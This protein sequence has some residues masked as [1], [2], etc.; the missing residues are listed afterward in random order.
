MKRTCTVFFHM[1]SDRQYAYKQVHVLGVQTIGRI[2]HGW[3]KCE[4]KKYR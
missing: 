1:D 4:G 3:E 2:L